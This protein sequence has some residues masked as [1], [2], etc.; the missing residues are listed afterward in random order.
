[1]P[2]RSTIDAAD[3]ALC[4]K[5]GADWLGRKVNRPTENVLFTNIEVRNGHGLTLGSDCSGGARNITWRHIFM[6]GRGPT[7]TINGVHT[8]GNGVGTGAGPS[9]PHWKTGRGRGGTWRDIMWDDIYGDTVMNAI[10]FS[11]GNY[12]HSP[13]TNMTATPK[14]FNVT[15]QNVRLT[16]VNGAYQGISTLSESPIHGLFL[17][18]ISF[19]VRC[20]HHMTPHYMAS[21]SD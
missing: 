12:I 21:C 7:C 8:C 19:T 9:G 17:K 18:N 13:P 11:G 15:V 14:I 6:N 1:M 16:N 5:S 20:D 3:D 2:P 4:I 10:A